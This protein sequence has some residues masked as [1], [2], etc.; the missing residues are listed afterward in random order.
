[1]KKLTILCVGVMLLLSFNTNTQ[2]MGNGVMIQQLVNPD[3]VSPMYQ[4]TIQLD[5]FTDESGDFMY[6]LTDKYYGPATRIS[7]EVIK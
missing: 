5:S 1:M 4:Y 2:E 7:F 3:K 6:Y